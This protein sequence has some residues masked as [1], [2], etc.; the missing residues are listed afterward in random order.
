M[1]VMMMGSAAIKTKEIWVPKPSSKKKQETGK[2]VKREEVIIRQR[3]EEQRAKRK[4]LMYNKI[5][6]KNKT[7]NKKHARHKR[8][9]IVGSDERMN[10]R[11]R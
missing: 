5:T 1:M 2:Q 10:Q 11:E 3:E 4:F 7:K 9:G 8:G 6:T